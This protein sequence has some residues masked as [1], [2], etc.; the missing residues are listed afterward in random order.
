MGTLSAMHA[1]SDYGV[2]YFKETHA[3]FSFNALPKERVS[4]LE[5]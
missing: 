4:F 2:H 3:P 5:K 1:K